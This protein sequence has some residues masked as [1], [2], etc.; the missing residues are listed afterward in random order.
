MTQR[1]SVAAAD[2]MQNQKARAQSHKKSNQ[3]K[4]QKSK[5]SSET[6]WA[7]SKVKSFKTMGLVFVGL[8]EMRKFAGPDI[9]GTVGSL[10]SVCIGSY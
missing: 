6:K 5:P 7:I 4:G 3:N 8:V 9:L 2:E 1:V 10:S